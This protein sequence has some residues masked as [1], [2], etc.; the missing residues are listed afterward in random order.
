MVMV[1]RTLARH[2]RASEHLTFSSMITY[3]IVL[4]IGVTASFSVRVVGSFPIAEF[5]VIA[6]APVLVVVHR[7]RIFKPG[8]TVILVLMG[9]WL[10][11]QM[12]TDAYRRTPAVDWLRGWAG[13]VFFALDLCCLT[14][15]LE[16]NDR[17]KV[18]FISGIAIGSL[19]SARFHPI[20]T[21]DP[22]KFGY[23]YGTMLIVILI[24]SYFFSRRRYLITGLL[25]AGLIAIN[26]IF[27]FR[28]PIL[29]LLVVIVLALPLIPEKAGPIKLLP[30]RG[31]LARVAVLAAMA[32]GAGV[33]S[34]SLIHWA[35]SIGLAGEDAQA[36]NLEQEHSKQGLLLG[37]RPEI[38]V[39]SRA[40]MESPILGH[41]SW[42]KDL[43]YI[44]MLNDIQVENGFQMDLKDLEGEEGVIPA[45]SHLMGAWVWAGVLGAI[46]WAYIF[47]LVL[48][49]TVLVSNLLPPLTPIYAWIL[50]SYL[51]AILFSPFGRE[52]RIIEAA[53]IVIMVDLLESAPIGKKTPN[54]M[55]RSKWHRMPPLGSRFRSRLYG[56]LPLH[57]Q[58]RIPGSIR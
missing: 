9:L 8:M 25:F 35:T 50:V 37:A 57:I 14:A 49:T 23:S 15:L 6:L 52:D 18:V 51:W 27:N 45:H 17:R 43:R 16:K 1:T 31:S 47:W 2:T 28:S 30:R 10:L 4:G 24:S 38:F 55:R 44:E 3:A 42:A 29:F 46:F 58:G 20:E 19:L 12:V 32:L 5:F 48:K 41:G 36:K 7:R 39:S 13:I 54:W 53:T 22:W 34:T 26:L 40:V 33:V 11:G 56:S 21:T